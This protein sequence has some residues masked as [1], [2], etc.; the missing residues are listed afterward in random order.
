LPASAGTISDSEARSSAFA[1]E[2]RDTVAKPRAGFDAGFF[3]FGA[4]VQV[5][6]LWLL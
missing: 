4:I 5:A 6:N 2:G 1:L 3:F